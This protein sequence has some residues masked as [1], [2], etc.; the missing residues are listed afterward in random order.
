MDKFIVDMDEY[1]NVNSQ[2]I[3]PLTFTKEHKNKISLN[4]A[5]WFYENRI[6]FSVAKSSSLIKRFALTK[7]IVEDYNLLAYMS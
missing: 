6:P 3:P 1:E 4:L 5:R 2:R 7:I